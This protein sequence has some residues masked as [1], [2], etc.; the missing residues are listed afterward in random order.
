MA[1]TSPFSDMLQRSMRANLDYYE[2]VIRLTTGY[3]EALAG[4]WGNV[5]LPVRLGT[6]SAQPTTPAKPAAPAIVL[7][8]ASG[9]EAVGAFLVDN[10]LARRVSTAVAT[11][12]FT[13]DSGRQIQPPLRIV[14]GTLTLDPGQSALVQVIAPIGDDLEPGVTFRG[15]LSVPGLAE[16]GI[17]IVLRRRADEEAAAPKPRK[18]ARKRKTTRKRST[19][20]KA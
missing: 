5:K 9:Q 20:K 3:F 19:T 1:E 11:S 4:I 7:E 6:G 15:E 14:P 18:R 17:R 12:A 16:N 2:S 13:D 10:K 8:E